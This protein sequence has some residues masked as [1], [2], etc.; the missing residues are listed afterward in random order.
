MRMKKYQAASMAEAVA[1]IKAE[2]GPNAVILHASESRKGL[3]GKSV[4]EVVAA[5]DGST[6]AAQRAPSVR[7]AA[8]QPGAPGTA[9]RRAA[10]VAE[11]R[12]PAQA[13][14]PPRDSSLESM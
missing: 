3:L 12:A 1:M 7:A 9:A 4:V 10:A 2:L 6:S 13:P 11:R 8:P 14:A 5:A